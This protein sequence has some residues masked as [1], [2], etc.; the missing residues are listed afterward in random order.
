VNVNRCEFTQVIEADPRA[1]VDKSMSGRNH[2]YA[3]D[4]GR[5]P[6]KR[7]RVR[8][9]TTKVEAAKKGEHLGDWRSAFV[10]QFLRE[11]EFRPVAQKHPCPFTSGISG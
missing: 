7:S 6:R 5:G 3:G 4:S 9:L 1:G 8:D 11:L 2:K 10:A